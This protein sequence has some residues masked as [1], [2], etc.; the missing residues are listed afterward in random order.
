[1]TDHRFQ[2]RIV[3]SLELRPDEAVLEIGAGPGNMTERLLAAGAR[4]W[5]VELDP[6]W[7]TTLRQKFAGQNA[8]QVLEA[9]ILQVPVSTVARLAGQPRIK[10]FGNLPYYI[11]SPCLLHL[12]DNHDSIEEM[13]VMV[14]QEV[15]ERIVALPGSADYGLFSV[16]CQYYTQPRI[17]FSIPPGAFHPQPEVHSA[18]VRMSIAPQKQ[19]LG[20]EDEGAFWKL[21]RAAFAHRRRTLCNNWKGLCDAEQLRHSL[22]NLGI[23]LRARAETL[24]LT[25]YACLYQ[26]LK[27]PRV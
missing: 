16:T 19:A 15:A 24:S 6:Q 18:L 5:A 12:F 13:V 11:T 22:S 25:Q 7:A 3:G 9:D 20:I 14:Q 26:A 1:M 27:S 21:V 4:I 10:V 23:D 2:E 8:V 17:L